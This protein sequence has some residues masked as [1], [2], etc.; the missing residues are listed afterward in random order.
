[1]NDNAP[2]GGEKVHISLSRLSLALSILSQPLSHVIPLY[3]TLATYYGYSNGH[4]DGYFSVSVRENCVREKVIERQRE[5]E[6]ERSGNTAHASPID[7]L[8][9]KFSLSLSLSLS[10]SKNL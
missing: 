7:C 9:L 2:S 1:M 5:R 8:M 10:L 6:R 4:L 3:W